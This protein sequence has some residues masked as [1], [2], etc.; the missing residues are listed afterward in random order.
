MRQQF[1]VSLCTSAMV[2][3]RYQDI[4]LSGIFAPPSESSQW[5]PLLPGTKVP[6]NF[7]SWERRFPGTF[8]PGSECSPGTFV[9]AMSVRFLTTVKDAGAAVKV[10]VKNIVQ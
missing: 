9:P 8:V 2:E 6:G 1:I 5:E 3:L 4:S 10:N 7:C